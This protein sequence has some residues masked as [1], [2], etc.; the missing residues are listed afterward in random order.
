MKRRIIL[1]LAAS[2]VAVLVYA[3]E[4]KWIVL[5]G[6]KTLEQA[7]AADTK[8]NNQIRTAVG[9]YQY[10]GFDV[11][12]LSVL[13]WD[14]NRK[15]ATK[16]WSEMYYWEN[17]AGTI[18]IYLWRGLPSGPT[19]SEFK[20]IIMANKGPAIKTYMENNGVVYTN[21]PAT[22]KFVTNSVIVPR[23]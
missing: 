21:L 2:I 15:C 1:T 5:T 23:P 3:Q 8:L 22:S 16:Y 6:N 14:S 19:G 9:D 17:Q 20:R 10:M 13:W 12:D 18:W 11:D 4:Q 7:W